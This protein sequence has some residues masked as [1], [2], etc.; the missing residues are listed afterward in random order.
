MKQA[1]S[2]LVL[3]LGGLDQGQP[4]GVRVEGRL[5][6]AILEGN[7]PPG[8]RLPSSRML[9]RDLKVSRHTVEW[10]FLQLESEGFLVRR[11][12]SGTFVADKVPAHHKQPE[13]RAPAKRSPA[14]SPSLSKRGCE[15]T[16]YPG[17][18]EHTI[19]RAFTPSMPALDLFPRQI[20]ARLLARAARQAGNDAWAYGASNGLV[21]LREA[22]AGHIA[23]TRAVACSPH[24][25]IVVSSAQ[26]GLDLAARVLLDPGD[27]AWVEDP[28]YPPAIRLL[29]AAGAKV[30]PVPTDT[31][32]FHA[33]AAMKIAPK[34]RLAYVTPSHQYPG[35]GLMSL[36]R[37]TT[38]L[39]WAER[40]S[41]WIIEDDYD[42]DF[43]Y[44]GRPL[45]ALQALDPAGRVIYIGTFNKMMFPSLR[46]AFLVVPR[47]FIDPFLAAKH[48]MDGHAPGH[49]QAALA[50]F[51][52]EGHLATHLRRMLRD[53]DE[54]RQALLTGLKSL[55]D[56]LEIGPAEAGLHVSAFLRR[57]RD[58]S[59]IAIQCAK[60][61]I[62]LHPLSRFYQGH[63]RAGFVLG[64]ACAT[65]RQLRS[66]LRVLS[67]ALGR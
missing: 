33:G 25:V 59:E 37:R 36:M 49:T 9:A 28:G 27:T 19:G 45:A 65:P 22:I 66:G 1:A 34:A 31:D 7:L 5:R 60:A 43:R 6:R 23:G 46:L 14:P 64:F 48:T 26:Q 24:Q 39:A 8:S 10:A 54:R 51:I 58:D 56:Q 40:E 15:L 67:A 32:G 41:G 12:G 42:G 30:V 18:S 11:A 47:G 29:R 57:R 35:G 3:D 53:Y 20:W 16:N 63:A 61:G 50:S 21:R 55:E 44:S 4:L 62:D 38:L 2:V 52:S 17:H 13:L